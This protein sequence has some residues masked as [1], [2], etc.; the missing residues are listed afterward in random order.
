MSS[1]DGARTLS[2]DDGAKIVA[3][4]PAPGRRTYVP[5]SSGSSPGGET[6]QYQSGKLDYRD[7]KS[8]VVPVKYMNQDIN[9][10]D[11]SLQ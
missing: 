3:T 7:L 5:S 1:I 8:G 2:D 10:L 11:S 9:T 4:K 6:Y